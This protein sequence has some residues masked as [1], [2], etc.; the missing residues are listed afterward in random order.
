V[1]PVPFYLLAVFLLLVTNVVL[2]TRP[3][4]VT[5][6]SK[7][8]A[9]A[10]DQVWYPLILAKQNTPRAA[11]R[12][13]NR[14]RYLAMRQRGFQEKASW[15]ERVLFPTRLREPARVEGWTPIPEPLLV[16]MAAMEQ[17]EPLWVY[18]ET[19][20][21]C[22]ARGDNLTAL[23]PPAN[24][25]VERELLDA[26]RKRHRELFP[27]QDSQKLKADWQSLPTYRNAFLVIWPRI[28]ITN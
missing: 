3:G 14:V 5:R 6:D 21:T 8:F 2:T 20:F 7:Q 19:V 15:W 25:P 24:D 28:D 13:V 27:A 11:K 18:D 10:M 4:V 26:A 9:N 12:F 16:A 23:K 22:V 17:M 1:L